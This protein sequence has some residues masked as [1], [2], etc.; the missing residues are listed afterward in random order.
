MFD[1]IDPNHIDDAP[2]FAGINDILGSSPTAAAVYGNPLFQAAVDFILEL[3][4][5]AA[6]QYPLDMPDQRGSVAGKGINFPQRRVVTQALQFLFPSYAKRGGG[7]I[8]GSEISRTTG[9]VRSESVRVGQMQKT[10]S[11]HGPTTTTSSST[12]QS[13]S[14]VDYADWLE[15]QAYKLLESIGAVIEQ[16]LS[17]LDIIACTTN[18]RLEQQ[19]SGL[20]ALISGQQRGT[21]QL[22][23]VEGELT[24]VE[25]DM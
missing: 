12:R 1:L 25:E 23:P 15:Q 11:F 20:A 7:S 4:P 5:G 22:L 21:G 2:V 19:D 6:L 10:T 16:T 18:S 13:F 17:G 24:Y 8:G 14:D 9:D 3:F